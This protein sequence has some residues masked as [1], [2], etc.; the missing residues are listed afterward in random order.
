MLPRC[1]GTARPITESRMTTADDK[2]ALR[3]LMLT[4]GVVAVVAVVCYV[5]T[6]RLIRNTEMVAQDHRFAEA[7]ADFRTQIQSLRMSARGYALTGDE[8]FMRAYQEAA[9]LT[10]LRLRELHQFGDDDFFHRP[11]L[12]AL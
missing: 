8:Q 11:R 9:V 5:N 7:L 12:D 6:D 10:R 2:R 1:A 4:I 3:R